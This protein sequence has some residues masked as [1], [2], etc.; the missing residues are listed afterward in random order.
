MTENHLG[1]RRSTGSGATPAEAPTPSC[2]PSPPHT[3]PYC[4]CDHPD[5]V[6]V[7]ADLVD[8]GLVVVI[9]PTPARRYGTVAWPGRARPV[10]VDPSGDVI[11][12]LPAE[13]G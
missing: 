13:E 5:D 12:R 3:S 8:E 2:E 1:D 4:I 9:A 6:L 10:G 11:F 7:P